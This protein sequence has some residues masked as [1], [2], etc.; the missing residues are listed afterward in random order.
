MRIRNLLPALLA[1]LV[2]SFVMGAA[3][4]Q[5]LLRDAEI[6]QYL[7]DYTDPILVAAGLETEAVEIYLVGSPELNAFVTA[8]LKIF[9]HT[10]LI[11][12]AE[13]PNEIEG[14]IAH[15][16]GHLAGGHQQRGADAYAQAARPAIMSLVLGAAII[17]AGG[18]V[19]A[20]VAIGSLGQTIGITE[21]LAYNRSQESA[22]DQA[23]ATY[24][25]QIGRS[26]QGLV[27]FFDKLNNRQ[28]IT[29]NRIDPYFL[30][31][32]LALQRM[33]ALR[34]RVATSTS[35]ANVDTPD[36]I[37]RL[38]L[39]QA[40]INGFMQGSQATLRQY[41]LK[42]QSAPARYARAVAYYRASQL[43]KATVE[44]GRLL[45]EQPD[46]P[47]FHELHGQMLFEHGKIAESVA[48][49]RRSVTLAPQYALLKINLARSLIALEDKASSDEAVILLKA[50]LQQEQDNGFAWAELARLYAFQGREE[51]ASLAQAQ[52]F[53]SS[54]NLAEAHRFASRARD[55]LTAGTPEHLQALDIIAASEEEARK[56]RDRGG[57][58]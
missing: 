17:A 55:K 32:P 56:A 47:F 25:E 18:P 39:I 23:A 36:Q 20:G 24:L 45:A 33:N 3:R 40:K 9:I 12:A 35:L 52:A 41:P 37:A 21:Y 30:T 29:A 5:T 15:E 11:T 7:R 53:F 10:G 6:E 1:C 28:L 14:V 50:A 43:D 57:R 48:P 54:G 51:L 34:S 2:V 22:A 42:D 44:I 58:R 16:T 49:H 13:T 26:G 8:G 27:D 4:A 46:N 31:H 19:D 38:R